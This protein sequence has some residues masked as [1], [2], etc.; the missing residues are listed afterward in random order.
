M[1]MLNNQ[2]V[3]G[4]KHMEMFFVFFFTPFFHGENDEKPRKKR[5]SKAG[6]SDVS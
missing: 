3:N 5:W 1:A 6:R 2:R 4:I